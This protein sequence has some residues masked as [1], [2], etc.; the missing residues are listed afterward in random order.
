LLVTSIENKRN[1][2]VSKNFEATHGKSGG[3]AGHILF[4]YAEIKKLF[5]ERQLKIIEYTQSGV[6]AQYVNILSGLKT[7]NNG[8]DES[9]SH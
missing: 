2:I 5:R 3:K 6:T 1:Y 7:V 4:G 9:I 8:V